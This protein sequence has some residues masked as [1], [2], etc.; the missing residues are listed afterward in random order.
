M[1]AISAILPSDWSV[2]R[3]PL[4]LEASWRALEATGIGTPFQSFDWMRLYHQIRGQDAV[5]VA[6][7]MADEIKAIFPL[8]LRGGKLTWF[9]EEL[10]NYNAPLLSAGLYS[11]LTSDGVEAMWAA[12]RTALG[13]PSAS[14]L[15]RQPEQIHGRPNPF[16]GWSSVVEPTSAYALTLGKDWASFYETLSSASTRKTLRKKQRA[17]AKDGVLDI[18]RISGRE[19]ILEHVQ[20]LLKWKHEQV[21]AT[22]GRNHFADPLHREMLARYAAENPNRTRIYAMTQDETPIALAYL[23]DNGP[24]PILYQTAYAPG[25]S[26]RQSPGRLLLNR[27][28]EDAVSEGREVVDFAVGDDPYKQDICD[29]KMPLTTSLSALSATGKLLVAKER[30]TLAAKGTIK[31]S[32]AL[33][34]AAKAIHAKVTGNRRSP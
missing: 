22:G 27:I 34:T 33:L 14:I 30:F 26:A 13:H 29:R 19:A 32:P 7:R 10:N 18:R 16:A 12:V 28:L 4:P 25:P 17:L 23:I 1:A 2:E 15:R 5:F 24:W 21:S 11:Q 9:G 6:G 20:L 8:V 31:A 3:S